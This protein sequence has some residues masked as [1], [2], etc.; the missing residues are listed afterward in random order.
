MN[1]RVAFKK[2]VNEIIL[3]LIQITIC[4]QETSAS[5]KDKYYDNVREELELQLSCLICYVDI[6]VT[7]SRE[8]G[9]DGR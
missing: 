3:D 1:L 4:Y 5:H 9:I 2:M 6:K 7:S 8:G